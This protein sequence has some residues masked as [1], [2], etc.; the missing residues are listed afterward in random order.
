MQKNVTATQSFDHAGIG[1]RNRGDSFPVSARLAED[2]ESAGLVVIDGDAKDAPPPNN[3]QKP[4]PANKSASEHPG[5]AAGETPPSS[6]SPAA[7]A[8]PQTTAPPSKRGARKPAE[9]QAPTGE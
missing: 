6:A 8:S 7:Q 1:A 4:P 5:A 2:L 9:G 3:K